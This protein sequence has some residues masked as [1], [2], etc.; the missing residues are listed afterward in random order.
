MSSA[1]ISLSQ[2]LSTYLNEAL[3]GLGMFGKVGSI[4]DVALVCQSKLKVIY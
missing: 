4:K 1:L 3:V 2:P